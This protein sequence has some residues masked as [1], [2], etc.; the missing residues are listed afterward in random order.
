[1][2]KVYFLLGGNLGDREKILADAIKRMQSSVGSWSNQSSLYETE[3]WGFEHEQ[4]FLNQVLVLESD[5]SA[6]QILDECQLIE[7]ELGRVRKKD[8]YSERTIDIDVLFYG[9]EIISSQRLTVPHPRIEERRFALIP[10]EE[11][12]SDFIHPVAKKSIKELLE[13]CPDKMEV[14]KYEK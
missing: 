11:V 1:M 6:M 2:V 7:K 3:P 13:E 12:V 10:L 5:L 8:Q 14:K 9:E 4:N